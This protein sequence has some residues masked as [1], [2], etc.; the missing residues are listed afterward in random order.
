MPTDDK[1]HSDKTVAM[2]RNDLMYSLYSK[3]SGQ[4]PQSFF[5][6]VRGND[7]GKRF[8]ASAAEVVIGR[9]SKC[10][11]QLNDQHVSG[12]HAMVRRDET[13][14]LIEDLESANG[15]FVNEK[16]VKKAVL[17]KND[18]VRIGETVFQVKL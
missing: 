8:L 3:Q 2:D 13:G 6:C 15:L 18:E 9:S 14:L 1:R 12:R 7:R 4:L 5:E 17:A 10:N 16:R 11:I